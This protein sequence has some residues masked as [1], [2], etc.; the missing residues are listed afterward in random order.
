VS[1]SI[2]VLLD[3]LIFFFLVLLEVLVEVLFQVGQHLLELFEDLE[4]SAI[5]SEH[6]GEDS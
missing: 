1:A 5:L 6:L 4:V 2:I 3:G